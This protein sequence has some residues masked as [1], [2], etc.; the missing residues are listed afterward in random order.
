MAGVFNVDLEGLFNLE[1]NVCKQLED[2]ELMK[3]KPFYEAVREKLRE[4]LS[5]VRADA[6]S[7]AKMVIRDDDRHAYKAVL[8]KTYKDR[9]AG[10]VNI[11][12]S[13][14][15]LAA[16]RGVPEPTGGVS[17][18]RRRRSVSGRTAQ[19]LSYY[20][21]DAGFILRFLNSGTDIRTARASGPTGRHSK[22]TWGGRGA[23]SARDFFGRSEVRMNQA[24]IDL[25]RQIIRMA[26]ERTM[27]GEE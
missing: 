25:G 23:I 8:R 13:N 27:F 11:L 26:E 2:I 24:A 15:R 12:S 19:T 7:K 6:V 18:I 10:N 9:L 16:R 14:K 5:K 21:A 20:G 4:Q 3:D 22:A 17:G 1:E